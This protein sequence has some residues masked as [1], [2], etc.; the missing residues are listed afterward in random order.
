TNSASTTASSAHMLNIGCHLRHPE[1]PP[2]NG[3][4]GGRALAR[5][6]TRQAC[7]HQRHPDDQ[8]RQHPLPSRIQ[9]AL[10]TTPVQ[11]RQPEF[12]GSTGPPWGSS[13]MFQTTTVLA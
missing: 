12:G 2:D 4:A 5:P 13:A 11:P 6:E 3:Q 7:H 1:S 10:N 8:R 9:A